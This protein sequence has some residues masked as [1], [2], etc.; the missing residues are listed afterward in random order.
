M[1]TSVC[2]AANERA[3][4][5]VPMIDLFADRVL[6]QRSLAIAG[7]ELPLHPAIG[8]DGRD[9]L[10]S[11]IGGIAGWL[12]HCIGTWRNHHRSA[13]AVPDNRLIGGIA[14][15]SAI[16]RELPARHLSIWSSSGS[17]EKRRQHPDPL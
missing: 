9:M 16:G 2:C 7:I 10:V 5:R 13:G 3:L 15:I 11:L 1:A 14:I 6:H 8:V 12:F 4:S 17:P